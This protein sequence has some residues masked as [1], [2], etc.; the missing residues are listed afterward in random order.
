MDKPETWNSMVLMVLEEPE[1]RLSTK[2]V[3]DLSFISYRLSDHLQV[4]DAAGK[5]NRITALTDIPLPA[6]PPR[7]KD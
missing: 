4:G 3:F 2:S 5:P 7:L 1:M 6:L